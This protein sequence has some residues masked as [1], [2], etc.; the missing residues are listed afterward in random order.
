MWHKAE[1]LGHP[2][3]LNAI[4]EALLDQLANQYTTQGANEIEL[5][6][7]QCVS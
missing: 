2:M 6:K 7:A 3:R 4:R 5:K 1:W